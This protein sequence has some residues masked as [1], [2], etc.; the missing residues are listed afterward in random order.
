MCAFFF[1]PCLQQ[2][3]ETNGEVQFLI[4]QDMSAGNDANCCSR[5]LSI[6]DLQGHTPIQWDCTLLLEEYDVSKK[7]VIIIA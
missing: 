5:R 7:C 6:G 2:R 1:V 4:K 3:S